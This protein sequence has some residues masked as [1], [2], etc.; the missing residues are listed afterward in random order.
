MYRLVR[1]R[2]ELVEKIAIL[3]A[4]LDDRLV[5]FVK[6]QF[7][8][9]RE[10]ALDPQRKELYYDFSATGKEKLAFVV[11]DRM[12]GKAESAAHL[13]MDVYREL[14]AAFLTSD[15]LQ[16]ELQKL[17]PGYVVNAASLF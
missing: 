15:D 12:S 9:R 16:E 14:A 5:E 2:A 4:G 1:V 10:Q 17:F 11:F 13:P 6:Y 7:F 3:R 8:L